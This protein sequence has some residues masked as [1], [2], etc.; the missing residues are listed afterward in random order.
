MVEVRCAVCGSTMKLGDGSI[1]TTELK[2][3][4]HYLVPETIRNE[5]IG[6]TTMNEKAKERMAALKEV[7]IDVSKLQALMSK[8]SSLKDIFTDD[9][10]PILEEIG[11]RGFLR[12]PEL[13]RRW[14]TAQT[15][16]LIK[17]S[18]SWTEA[19]NRWYDIRYVY[20][21]TKKELATDITIKYK[22][23]SDRR[24]EFFRLENFKDI[25][26]DLMKFNYHPTYEQKEF[27]RNQIKSVDTLEELLDVISRVRWAFPRRTNR[28]L[29][30]SWLNCF[31]GAGA[32]YTLQNIIRTHGL[33]I[34][35]CKDMQS[36]LEKVEEIFQKI[37]SYPPRQ[38]RWDILM[39]LLIS[40]VKET[41]F[42]LKY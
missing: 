24:L 7:G 33:V 12:N 27:Y 6:E 4:I 16:R 30:A 35:S 37:C 40:S 34:P 23:P 38:R 21:M 20:R 10:D 42:E 18:P 9:N 28:H 29:P 31:K 5:N 13:F 26:V 11:E 39:S 1:P 3:G 17:W 8:D 32:Y 2:D 15:F 36:S 41:H 22:S 19:A 14:I 25:F